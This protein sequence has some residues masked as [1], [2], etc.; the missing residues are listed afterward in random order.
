MR[1]FCTLFDRNYLTR[2][3]ALHASLGRHCDDFMLLVLCL[4]EATRDAL[5]SMKLP[6]LATVSIAT[7][8]AGDGDLARARGNRSPVEFYFTCKP[9]LMLRALSLFPGARRVT[10]LDS[11]LYYFASPALVED[12]CADSPAAVTPHG[13]P[14]RLADRLQY[15]KFNAGWVSAGAGA[16]GR[17]FLEW[18]RARCI[19]WCYLRVEP[20]RFGDQK[21]LDQVPG[22]F[23]EACVVDHPGA[24]VAPWNLDARRLEESADGPVVDGRPVVFF[25]FHGVRRVLSRIYDSG[26]EGYQVRLSAPVRRSLYDPYF[27][28]LSA[29]AESLYR[30]PQDLRRR[31]G[32]P[33]AVPTMR[34]R[35]GRLRLAARLLAN[36]TAVVGP[37]AT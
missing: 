27:S 21:Y 12:A 17:R 7:L 14:P 23:P 26:L 20:D 31:L 19:E 37:R 32:A 10:Y 9:V 33:A 30:L 35:L 6:R 1:I 8:E 22:L 36:G 29:A 25:H 16:E 4:D 18:W 13:F 28:D 15:G 34:Q 2:G 11:D 5:E 24:N 3:M